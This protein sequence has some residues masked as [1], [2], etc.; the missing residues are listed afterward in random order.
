MNQVSATR[1]IGV[2]TFNF[3]DLPDDAYRHW[4]RRYA[5]DAGY[6]RRTLRTAINAD[7]LRSGSLKE[8]LNSYVLRAYEIALDWE[9]EGIA[10]KMIFGASLLTNQSA[11]RHEVD[12]FTAALR[13]GLTPEETK[14]VKVN[15]CAR[16]CAYAWLHRWDS[17]RFELGLLRHGAWGVA[18]LEDG[19]NCARSP[20]TVRQLR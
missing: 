20:V 15:R 4:R 14:K 9:A 12:V 1:S 7:E 13:L 18:T 8:K 17:V 2:P 16:A 3:R 5:E 11:L 6:F 19:V 10:D